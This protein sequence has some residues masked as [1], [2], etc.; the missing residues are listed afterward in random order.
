LP[1]LSVWGPGL[2][3]GWKANM[4]NRLRLKCPTPGGSD[5]R[6]TIWLSYWHEQL[7]VIGCVD[8]RLSLSF[9]QGQT[10]LA[11]IHSC[12][13]IT[14]GCHGADDIASWSKPSATLGFMCQLINTVYRFQQACV[15]L[16]LSIEWGSGSRPK[17][18]AGNLVAMR[19]L[20]WVLKYI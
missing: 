20:L 9:C 14:T 11:Q 7:F 12:S 3:G 5:G 8:S 2:P 18:K 10:G 13:I 6:V 4:W 16:S 19:P 1:T 17:V 15:F